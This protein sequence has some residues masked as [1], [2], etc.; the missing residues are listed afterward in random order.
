MY[1]LKFFENPCTSYILVQTTKI[2]HLEF[3]KLQKDVISGIYIVYVFK[4]YIAKPLIPWVCLF[5][6]MENIAIKHVS[7]IV[8]PAKLGMFPC[9]KWSDCFNSNKYGNTCTEQP[10]DNHFHF[11]ILNLT[12]ID[13]GVL[14][15]VSFIISCFAQMRLFLSLPIL[16]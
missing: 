14:P 5:T 11:R 9:Q 1:P 6:L 7:L 16:R 15:W 8:T 10:L 13:Y 3:K 12:L 2:F 4:E